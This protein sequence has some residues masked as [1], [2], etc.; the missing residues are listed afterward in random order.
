VPFVAVDDGRLWYEVVG[1]GPPV[2]LLHS[3]LADSRQ[4]DDQVRPFSA[5]FT[6]ARYDQRGYGRSDPVTGPHAP[7]DDA[8]SVLEALDL[9]PAAL[10]G[11]SQGA[12]IS[13]GVALDRPELV[14]GL[15]LSAPGAVGYSEWSDETS[16]KDAQIER[17]IDVGDRATGLDRILELWLPPGR[18]PDTDVRVRALVAENLDAWFL[19]DEW[20][21]WP[22]TPRLDRA[23]EVQMPVLIV[24]AEHDVPEIQDTGRRLGEEIEG[25]VVVAIP[26]SDHLV[27]IRNPDAFTREGLSFLD[28]AFR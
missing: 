15:L 26:R 10:V 3:G 1:S 2:V 12:G 5:R 14:S 25:S 28:R 13:L 6:V 18:F 4:W 19:P 11:S 17:A 16:A 21:R 27:N 7:I 20:D 8:A 23:H 9:G 22:E 24:L